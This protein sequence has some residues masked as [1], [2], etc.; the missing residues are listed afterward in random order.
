MAV[1]GFT[2][3]GAPSDIRLSQIRQPTEMF[4]WSNVAMTD[5]APSLDGVS[6]NGRDFEFTYAQPGF[7][8]ARKSLIRVMENLGGRPILERMYRDWS[9]QPHVG[10]TIFAAAI[11]LM[12]ID[13]QTDYAAWRGIPRT[14][15]VLIVANHPFGVIDGLTIGHLATLVRRDVKIMA[16][17]LLCQPPEVRPYILP[18]DFGGTASARRTSAQTRKS[19]VEWLA[20]DHV[21]VVFP[22]GGVA[23]AATPFSNEILESAWHPFLARLLD[24][25]GLTILPAFF[26]GQNSRLF[27]VVS[28]ISY[29]LRLALLIF[30]SMRHF[31][32]TIH[33]TLGDARSSTD[34]ADA[35]EKLAKVQKLRQITYRLAGPDGPDWRRDFIWPRHI[36]FT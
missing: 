25:P 15:P 30:E 1:P 18:V 21:L 6:R 22:A 11:R 9:A 35:G 14:G 8:A 2:L 3:S 16:H 5:I 28:H 26:A 23:T 24:V 36:S 27:H 19:A 17:S 31:N 29:T 33:V 13:V 20:G 4:S 12:G 32:N 10:E 7:S 34:F